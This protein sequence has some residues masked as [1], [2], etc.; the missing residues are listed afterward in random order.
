MLREAGKV[1]EPR[2]VAFLESPLR[3]RCRRTMLRYAIER[4][5]A[6]ER[7]RLMAIPRV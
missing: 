7:R 5:G 1:D 3:R 6:D 4:L 2:L